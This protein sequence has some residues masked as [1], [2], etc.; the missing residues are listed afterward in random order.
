MTIVVWLNSSLFNGVECMRTAHFFYYFNFGIL[1]TKNARLKGQ[2]TDT[3]NR[4]RKR[5][6]D[7]FITLFRF[8]FLIVT[9]K[10]RHC[11][12]EKHSMAQ[13]NS[14]THEMAT[15]DHHPNS[16]LISEAIKTASK[17]EPHVTCLHITIT[18]ELTNVDD[19]IIHSRVSFGTI[20]FRLPRT[21]MIPL[22]E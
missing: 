18:M 19:R 9:L 2:M 22:S 11:A 7:F 14:A 5:V 10:W 15:N 3:L 16:S 1:L 12:T 20:S 4:V 6:F 21:A 17:M 13:L 8:A